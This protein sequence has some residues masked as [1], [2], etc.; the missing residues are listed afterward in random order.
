MFYF[1]IYVIVQSFR[2]VSS[3][4]I[5]ITHTVRPHTHADS[6]ALLTTLLFQ[7][8]TLLVAIHI[9]C[10]ANV[11]HFQDPQNPLSPYHRHPSHPSLQWTSSPAH[12]IRGHHYQLISSVD[13]IASSSLLWISPAHLILGHHSQVIDPW[14]STPAHQGPSTYCVTQIWA[15]F[16]THKPPVTLPQTP[17]P[18][19]P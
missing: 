5:P 19:T 12:L 7:P 2:Q 3:S 18:T 6:H 11:G 8:R 9:L 4:P 15:T 10:H 17:P 16:K 13:I 14:T 1:F